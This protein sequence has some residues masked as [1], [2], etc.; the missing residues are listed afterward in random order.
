M[1]IVD[2]RLLALL[3]ASVGDVSCE[4]ACFNG[5]T[6]KD[7][8]LLQERAN[9]Q[10]VFAV[11]FNGIE[12]LSKKFLPS[13]DILMD[14]MGKTVYIKKNYFFQKDCSIKVAEFLNSQNIDML[15]MKGLGLAEYY[16]DPST[17][18]F[19]DLD[20][21][22]FDSH[23]KLNRLIEEK[24][25]KIEYW[26]THDIFDFEGA[27]VEHHNVFV[28]NDSET[29]KKVNRYLKQI[30]LC[31]KGNKSGNIY[32]PCPDFNAVYIIRHISKHFCGE[33]VALRH[34]LDWGLF[35]KKDGDNVDWNT[36]NSFLKETKMIVACN[37]LTRLAEV[38]TGFD[39]SRFY[40]GTV[41]EEIVQKTLNAILCTTLHAEEDYSTPIRLV[42]KMRRVL[43]YKWMYD[44][45]LIPD[46]FW[47]EFIWSSVKS[48][49]LRPSQI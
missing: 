11:A 45:G 49:I 9:K 28:R 43:S 34:I 23:S 42:R 22:T 3:K 14:W 41:N 6:D 1:D 10:G 48:H 7:W 38:V 37:T 30:V 39:L 47:T 21:Y 33:G 12:K 35:L 25:I 16:P 20:I 46:M 29:A 31:D 15:V 13:M 18:E 4:N 24:N 8:L 32:Y 36:T 40:I 2:A 44:C 27:H 17:R 5:M 26:D 19:G